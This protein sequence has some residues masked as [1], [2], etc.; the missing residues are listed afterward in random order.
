MSH[1][2]NFFMGNWYFDSDQALLCPFFYHAKEWQQILF[3]YSSFNLGEFH[4]W[5]VT[6]LTSRSSGLA[7]WWG[8]MR[9]STVEPTAHGSIPARIIFKKTLNTFLIEIP[10]IIYSLIASFLCYCIS[11]LFIML[12]TSTIYSQINNLCPLGTTFWTQNTWYNKSLLLLQY[13]S[14]LFEYFDDV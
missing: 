10:K 2:K 7:A 14:H 6:Y 11:W 1:T 9:T 13:I 4:P 5:M 3:Y 8:L 12:F